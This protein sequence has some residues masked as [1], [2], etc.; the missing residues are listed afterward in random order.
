MYNE[1]VFLFDVV[2]FIGKETITFCSLILK[3]AWHGGQGKVFQIQIHLTYQ[4]PV[5]L[6]TWLTLHPYSDASID[7]KGCGILC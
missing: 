4:T 6:N 3:E 1:L 5:P 2:P 7:D